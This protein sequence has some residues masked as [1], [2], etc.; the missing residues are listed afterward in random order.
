MRQGA[1]SAHPAFVQGGARNSVDSMLNAYA[2]ENPKIV[3]RLAKDIRDNPRTVGGLAGGWGEP[4]YHNAF[5]PTPFSKQIGL[6]AAK[7]SKLDDVVS[8]LRRNKP[9]VHKKWNQNVA[10]L[11]GDAMMIKAYEHLYNYDA[12]VFKQIFE[13]R[14]GR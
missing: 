8:L 1:K 2:G 13:G 6:D 11:S 12:I 7:S 9:T 14:M 5:Y 3:D 4:A 10:I